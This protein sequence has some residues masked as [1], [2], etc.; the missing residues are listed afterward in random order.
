MNETISLQQIFILIKKRIL[1][2]I[3]LIIL[4]IGIAT[5]LSFYYVTPLYQAQTQILVNQKTSSQ[6]TLWYQ[7][8]LDMQLI[9]TY[10]EIFT[11]DLILTQVIDRL[12]LNVTPGQLKAKISLSNVNDS[13][14]VNIIITDED[15]RQAVK[16][17]NSLVEI[18]KREIPVLINVDNINVLTYAKNVENPTPIKPNKTLNIAIGATIGLFVSIGAVFL[19]EIL[20][21]T[22]K[23]EKDVEE[24]LH[25]PMM[26]V[27]GSIPLEKV[28]KTSAK[29]S[30]LRGGQDAWFEK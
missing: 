18:V 8:E 23:S 20:D 2:I 3:S 22:I 13:K 6:E 25:I 12:D 17:A 30:K 14:V 11:S 7:M 27:V 16:I 24:V 26:G 5:I 28:K 21:T 4:A 19:L 1:L 9:N 10:N 15:H 29:S